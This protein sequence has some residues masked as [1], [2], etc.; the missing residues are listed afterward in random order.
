MDNPMATF[1]FKTQTQIQ[2]LIDHKDLEGLKAILQSYVKNAWYQV[3]FSS[4]NDRGIHG[5]CPS[6]MLHAILSGIFAYNRNI[7]C[8][9]LGETSILRT[10]ILALAQQYASCFTHQSER[11]LPKTNKTKGIADCCITAKEF[12]GILLTI[13]AVCRS[14]KGRSLLMN[15]RGTKFK[16]KEVIDD[17]LLLLELHLQWEAYLSQP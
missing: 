3:R 7:F 4:A 16:T 13:A 15:A 6:E 2:K 5:A 10:N 9:M 12:W 1:P 8:A 14:S 11:D 17:W